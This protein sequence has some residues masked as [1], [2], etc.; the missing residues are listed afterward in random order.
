MTQ[1]APAR[2]APPP[3]SFTYSE[4]L[5][6]WATTTAQQWLEQHPDTIVKLN[7]IC[8][9]VAVFDPEGCIL[10][11]QRAAHDTM[12]NTWEIPGGAADKGDESIL[13][14][15]AREVWEETG[16][17]VTRFTGQIREGK[18][19]MGGYVFGFVKGDASRFYC[20]YSFVAEVES[21]AAVTLDPK[22]HQDYVWAN[23]QDIKSK[24]VGDRE[25]AFDSNYQMR[26]LV[27]RALKINAKVADNTALKPGEKSGQGT[28]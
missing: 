22:E 10:L 8:A 6:P 23:A 4:S 25:L 19:P 28:D 14:G 16:L 2:G 15:A 9:N 7:G 18:A 21:C 11:V 24:K 3:S 26:W 13:H 12:P 17:V 20:R 5:A 27:G 1:P